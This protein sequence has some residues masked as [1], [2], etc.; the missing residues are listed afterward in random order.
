[1]R[2]GLPFTLAAVLAGALFIW[3]VWS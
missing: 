3:F 1:M 2:L